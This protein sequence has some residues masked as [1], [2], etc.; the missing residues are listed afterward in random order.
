[1]GVIVGS[2]ASPMFLGAMIMG[3]LGGLA[4]EADRQALGRARS[5]A[6]FEMLVN[7]FSAGILG[8]VLAIVGFFGIAPAR[9]RPQQ[10]A[11]ATRSNWLVDAQP[12]AAREHL[13]RARQGAVPQ[14]RHQPRRAHAARHRSRS[15]ETGKSILFL[16][17]ANPGP[18]LGLLLAFT[19]FGVG[20]AEATRP[21]AIIIQF[22]GGIHEI[23]F[24]YVLMKPMLI[25]AA[26]ARRHDRRRDERA[27]STPAASPRHR[28]GSIIAVLVADR[29]AAAISA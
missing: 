2:P 4:H 6:G 9:R 13:H 3:P 25:L 1:M 7:N 8:F 29:A 18:G 20:I 22:F 26:I 27:R 19:F 16:L 14:Q 12:A 21:G 10:R 11:R 28:P 5:S 24:P 23:Y 17:E 15:Q